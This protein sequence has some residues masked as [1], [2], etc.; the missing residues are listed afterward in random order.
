MFV[1]IVTFLH[2]TAAVDTSPPKSM[3]THIKGK[4]YTCQLFPSQRCKISILSV[5]DFW[6]WVGQLSKNI[7]RF[8]DIQKFF[9]FSTMLTK[10]AA[11]SPWQC[12]LNTQSCNVPYAKL[13]SY[14]LLTKFEGHTGRNISPWPSTIQKRPVAEGQYSPSMVPSIS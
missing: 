14:I 4:C 9:N 1:Y 8:L 2:G 3:K 6:R 5:P 13:H 12:P 11:K 7:Q 10:N